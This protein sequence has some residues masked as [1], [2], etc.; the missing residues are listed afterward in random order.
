MALSA[1]EAAPLLLGKR[2]SSRYNGQTVSGIITEVEAYTQDDPASHTYREITERNRAMFGSPGRAYIYF[3]YGIHYCMN[4]VCGPVGRGEA[5]LIRSIQIDV[6]RDI[7][8]SRRFKTDSPTQNQ[9]HDLSNGP[10]KL[11]QALGITM[12][13]NEIDLLDEEL[14]IRLINGKAIESNMI[15]QTRRIGISKNI[16]APWRWII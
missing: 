1:P 9:L 10:G 6:G 15:T 2:I 7:A 11:V 16:D 13:D 14:L 3:T 8:S 4:I 12:N 5:V